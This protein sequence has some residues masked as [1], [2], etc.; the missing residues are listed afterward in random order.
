[1]TKPVNLVSVYFDTD[2][3]KLHQRGLSLRV[4]RIGRRLAAGI[5][6]ERPVA[7]VAAEQLGR[8]WK[9][10]LKSGKRL[11]TLDPQ[12]RHRLRIQAKK[13]RYAADF[14]A[15]SF[16]RKKFMRRRKNFVAR[17]EQLQDALG[18]LHV[19]EV[20][21]EFIVIAPTAPKEFLIASAKTFATK[22]ATCGL[23]QCSKTRTIRSPRRRA[24][25][26]TPAGSVLWRS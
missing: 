6:R 16:P 8:R 26:T 22:S 11:D 10:I 12:R 9:K 21:R 5:L 24:P 1:V 4:R 20:A 18:D 19:E 15:T 3:L 7:A 23:M 2:K 17:L 13:L 14:F 25:R